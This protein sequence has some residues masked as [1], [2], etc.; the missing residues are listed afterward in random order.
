MRRLKGGDIAAVF[1]QLDALGWV[2]RVPGLRP[3]E[4]ARWQV[5]PICHRLFEERAKSETARRT[6]D[7][8]MITTMMKGETA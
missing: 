5:N 4:A 3:T 1:D 6:R 7:R 8:E 2:N